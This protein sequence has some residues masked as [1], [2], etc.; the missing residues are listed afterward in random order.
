MVQYANQVEKRVDSFISYND[1]ELPSFQTQVNLYVAPLGSYDVIL[2]INWLTKQ[3]SIVN[4]EDKFVSC[5]DDFGNSI[6]ILRSQR[7]FELRH[8]STMQLNKSQ[9]KGCSIFVAIVSD[10]DNAKK[11]PKDYPVLRE[12]W[13]VFPRDLTKLSSKREFVFSIELIP[14]IEPQSRAPYRMTTTE[15]YELKAQLQ[16]FLRKGFIRPSVSLWG[17]PV[18]FVTKKDGYHQLRIKDKDIPKTTFQTPDGHYE[19]TEKVHYL[20]HVISVEV[21]SIDPPKVKAI[22]DWPT[23]QSVIEVRSFMGLAG[24]YKKHVEGFSRIA[25]PIASLQKKGKK[26][27]WTEKHEESFQLL[28][29]KLTIAPVL[30]I[31][32]PNRHFTVIIDTSGEGIGALLMQK[33]KVVAFE[34]RKI[35]QY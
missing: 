15:L 10:L 32:D 6:E 13:D 7:P 24:Y 26:S 20:G 12:F 27:E 11:S 28:K 23:P 9:R 18:I 34:S 29:H 22:I 17:A 25:T 19:F 16:E 3:K 4:Y 8:I 33:G 2:G 14:G 1:L 31:P 30:T 21:I 35:K 5:K